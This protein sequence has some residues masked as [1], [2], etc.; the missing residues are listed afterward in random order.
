MKEYKEIYGNKS[1]K[2]RIKAKIEE[3]FI[4]SVIK[5]KNE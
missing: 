2:A 3:E 4:K 5:S 1:G